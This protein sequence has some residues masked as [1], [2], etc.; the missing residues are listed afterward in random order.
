MRA[1][2]TVLMVAA[3]VVAVSARALGWPVPAGGESRSGD[4]E[5]LLTFDDGPSPNTAHILDELDRR[6]YKA[7]FFWVGA[8][9]KKGD[10]KQLA[11]VERVVTSGH[12]IANHTVTHAHLCRLSKLQVNAEIDDNRDIFER[13]AGMPVRLFRTPYGADCP[14]IREALAKRSMQHMHWDIDPQEW[15]NRSA[16]YASGYVIHKLQHLDQRAIL[17][18]HDTQWVTTK[19]LPLVFDWIDAENRRRA[20]AKQ[21]PIRVV[22]PTQ[23]M[24][25]QLDPELEPWARHWAGSLAD[26]ISGAIG[27]LIP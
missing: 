13:L 2:I 18:M 12:L 1:L 26:G 27:Q 14:V 5:L 21:R 9:V 25:E 17:L 15:K 19:A 22:S 7:I 8:R 3:I 16:K 10:P 6:G 11:I 23:W 24:A 20:K 4:P